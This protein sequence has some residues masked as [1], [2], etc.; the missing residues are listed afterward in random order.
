[1]AGLRKI[2]VSIQLN[3]QH[4]EVGELVHGDKKIYFK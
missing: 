3:K 1:M 4:L 2:F